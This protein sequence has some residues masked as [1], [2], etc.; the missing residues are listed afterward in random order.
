[1]SQSAFNKLFAE[2][3]KTALS[4]PGSAAC[5]V[6]QRVHLHA[7]LFQTAGLLFQTQQGELN[8]LEFDDEIS[9]YFQQQ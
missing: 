9:D 5:R 4:L 2:L 8:C 6:L 3:E 7:V 1:M